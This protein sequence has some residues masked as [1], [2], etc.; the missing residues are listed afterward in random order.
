[1]NIRKISQFALMLVALFSFSSVVSA[2]CWQERG[3]YGY[4]HTVCGPGP[5]PWGPF[6]PP[7][8]PGPWGPPNPGWGP[9]PYNPGPWNP[10]NCWRNWRGVLICN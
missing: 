2:A 9:G 10:Q 3:Y 4:W 5:G 8:P 6:P 7:P 1:M